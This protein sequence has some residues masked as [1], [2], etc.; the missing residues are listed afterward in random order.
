MKHVV[1]W[2]RHRTLP[3]YYDVGWPS[4]CKYGHVFSQL[5]LGL[6]K[7]RLLDRQVHLKAVDEA[8]RRLA[9]LLRSSRARPPA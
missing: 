7:V 8:E 3:T 4:L 5:K 1:N 6:A 2:T 9:E